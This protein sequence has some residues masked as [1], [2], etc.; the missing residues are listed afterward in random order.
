[1][2]IADVAEA[3]LRMPDQRRGE[4]GARDGDHLAAG[5]DA[6]P[7]PV[8]VLE[9]FEHPPCAGAEVDE[10]VHDLIP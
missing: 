6:D 5:V 9:Q 3:D 7:P 10:E 2:T 8:M 1:M 4:L